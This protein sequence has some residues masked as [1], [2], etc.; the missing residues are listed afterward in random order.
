[1]AS[2]LPY[3][4]FLACVEDL[5]FVD[6]NLYADTAVG[7]CGFRKAVVDVGTE[8]LQRNGS[9]VIMLGTCD[10]GTAETACNVGL[11][12]LGARFHCS[13]DSGTGCS[14]ERNS[15][16]EVKCDSFRNKLCV[17]I[18]SLF[19]N[20]SQSNGLFDE[21]F[22]A[23]SELFDLGAALA[24]NRAGSCTVNEYLNSSAVS[25]YLDFRNSGRC[26]LLLDELSDLVVFNDEIA[27][28][29]IANKPSGI[30]VTDNAYSQAVR[31]NFLSHNVCPPILSLPRSL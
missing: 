27:E 1:M 20:D 26:D 13:V 3:F 8:R 15:L 29:I 25:F 23:L 21:F 9:L 28:L 19:L 7:R 22:D 16:F 4:E 12:T 31:V 5:T 14:S 18:P 2:F 10:F 11:Y 24:D 30:P 17:K 6:P